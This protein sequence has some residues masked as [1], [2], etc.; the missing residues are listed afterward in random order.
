MPKIQMTS[1][2]WVTKRA[3]L[4]EEHTKQESLAL[5]GRAGFKDWLLSTSSKGGQS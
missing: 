2:E 4:A 3:A 1:D 5:T